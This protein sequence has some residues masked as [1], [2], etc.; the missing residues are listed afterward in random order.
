MILQSAGLYIVLSAVLLLA[1]LVGRSALPTSIR[2]LVLAGLFLRVIGALAYVGLFGSLYGGGDYLMYFENGSWYAFLIWEGRAPEVVDIWLARQWW[3]TS[4][5][6]LFTGLI[7]T[8]LGPNLKAAAIVFALIGYAG[9]LLIAAA[10][11][12]AFPE[13]ARTRYLAWL[14]LFPSLWF[15][16]AAIGKDALV[17]F[18]LGLAAFGFAGR[19]GSVHWVVLSIGLA[20]IFAVRPQVAAVCTVAVVFGMVFGS[21]GTMGVRHVVQAG[22]ATG[23]TMLVLV[24][25]GGALGF[26]LSDP[27]EVE[28][29]L[30]RRLGSSSIGGSAIAERGNSSMSPVSAIVNVAFRPFP[31]EARGVGMM[32]AAVEIL[33]LWVLI[34]LN[35][36]SIRAF[37]RRHRRARLFLFAVAFIVLYS[38]LLG[39]ALGNMG[40][41]ARQR[42]F[43]YPFL[44]MIMSTPPP[45]LW[46]EGAGSK[47]ERRFPV[48]R[49]A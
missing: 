11:R 1:V 6:I 23:L 9:I 49:A 12:H 5:T 33:T 29:Y 17:L 21:A 18:G 38:I 47:P 28:M 30:D 39:F 31:W 44:F 3:G 40:I 8:V 35:A 45:V 24:S 34:V 41:I 32:I 48:P 27:A 42:I 46:A 13:A 16:P 22:L 43:L 19:K 36:R 25:A 10:F 7:V 15:W 2:H 4:F 20:L 14:V 26:E 37:L